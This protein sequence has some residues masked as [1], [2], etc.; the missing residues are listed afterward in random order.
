MNINS[1]ILRPFQNELK[2]LFKETSKYKFYPNTSRVCNFYK[3]DHISPFT[4]IHANGPWLYTNENKIIYDVGGYGMLGFGHNPKWVLNILNKPHV[5]ANAMTPSYIQEEITEFLHDTTKYD[6]FAFLNSGSEGIEFTLR[7]IDKINGMKIRSKNYKK[8]ITLVLKSGF[9][10]RTYGA[11]S[12][13]N[14]SINN[15]RT[16][17]KLSQETNSSLPVLINN[18]EDFNRN[19]FSCLNNNYNISAVFM[20]PVMGEG[21]PGTPL[22]VEYYNLVRKLTDKYDIPLVIDSVQAGLRTNGCLSI[23]EYDGFNRQKS[24]DF[25]IFSKAIT[26][27]HYPLSI[28]AIDKKYSCINIEGIYGNSMCANPKALE[29]CHETLNRFYKSGYRNRILV[30]GAYFKKMLRRLKQKYPNMISGVN[31]KGLLLALEFNKYINTADGKKSLEY[32]CRVNGLNVIHG[33]NNSLRFTPHFNISYLEIE[34]IY[35]IL[36]KVI[37]DEYNKKFPILVI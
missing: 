18:K 24:P 7:Y 29:V 2:K 17:P 12:L 25:E 5:M 22:T 20:E 27:G 13:S 3:K 14:S 21:S 35:K 9:H 36:D 6:K 10:G 15:Y 34:L 30:M 33:G 1:K 26:C 19:F 4:P 23:T 31:G 37:K 11:A 28:I 8:N 16:M 32:N